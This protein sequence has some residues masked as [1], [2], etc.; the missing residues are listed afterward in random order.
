MA[1]IFSTSSI[2]MKIASFSV[3]IGLILFVIGFATPAWRVYGSQETRGLWQFHTCIFG[4]RT[5]SYG[6]VNDFHRAIQAMECIGLIGY[7]LSAVCVLL[8]LCAD[9]FRRR[10][11]LQATTALTFAGIIFASIGYA[12][13]GATSD[14]DNRN[15]YGS[16]MGW[17]M[18]VS[19][20]GTILYGV[21][22]I[23]LILQLVR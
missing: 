10:N 11:C 6:Q 17:S 12:L 13:F 18:G 19:L 22:G 16:D 14:G 21:A 9:S 23:M 2:W 1:N 20:A 7:V 4:C 5:V 3:L 15:G 8:Y